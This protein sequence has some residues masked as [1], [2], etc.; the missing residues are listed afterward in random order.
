MPISTLINNVYNIRYDYQSGMASQMSWF[1]QAKMKNLLKFSKQF[2][3]AQAKH[4]I[5]LFMTHKLTVV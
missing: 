1:L 2:R 3:T 4:C 5:N